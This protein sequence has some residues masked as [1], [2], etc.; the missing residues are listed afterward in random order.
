LG[1]RGMTIAD[2]KAK[3]GLPH[4]YPTTSP[5]YSAQRSEMAKSNGLGQGGRAG[6]AAKAAPVKPASTKKGKTKAKAE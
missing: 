4:N 2:H 1:T 5:S 6:K 3:W